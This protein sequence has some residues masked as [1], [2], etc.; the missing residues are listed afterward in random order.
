MYSLQEENLTS[1]QDP[2]NDQLKH[3]LTTKYHYE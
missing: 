2:L 1:I 3:L